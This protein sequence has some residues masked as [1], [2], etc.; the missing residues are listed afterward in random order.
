[1]AEARISE[2]IELIVPTSAGVYHRYEGIGVFVVVVVVVVVD[3]VV[4]VV[5]VGCRLSSLRG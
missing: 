5:T 3:V 4:D 1:M 2:T